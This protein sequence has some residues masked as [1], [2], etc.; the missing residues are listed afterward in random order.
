MNTKNGMKTNQIIC[1]PK[2]KDSLQMNIICP[3]F[4]NTKKLMLSWHIYCQLK[5]QITPF[6]V[7]HVMMASIL[8]SRIQIWSNFR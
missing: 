4:F 2:I 1:F 6:P 3:F 5:D 8:Y 7:F